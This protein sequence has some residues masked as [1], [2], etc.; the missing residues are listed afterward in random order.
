MTTLT[1]APATSAETIVTQ[2]VLPCERPAEGVYADPAMSE[3][4]AR[5]LARVPELASWDRWYRPPRWLENGHA[6]TILSSQLR[7]TRAV[8]Y[9]R[10]LLRTPDGGTLALDMLTAVARRSGEA[11]DDKSDVRIAPGDASPVC[12]ANGLTRR[13]SDE[14]VLGI[15]AAM[16]AYDCVYFIR[17]PARLCVCVRK[18]TSTSCTIGRRMTG[19]RTAWTAPA[20]TTRVRHRRRTSPSCSSPPAWAAA[21]RRAV[22]VRVASEAVRAER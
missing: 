1:S 16:R 5:V 19:P 13:E 18:C 4:A 12:A 8:R 14:R 10:E 11:A 2:T 21:R 7:K 9:Y 17:L 3:L 6:H 20:S 22:R 15:G